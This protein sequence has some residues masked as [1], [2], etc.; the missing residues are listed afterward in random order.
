[1]K[2][3]IS[4]RTDCKY[5]ALHSLSHCHGVLVKHSEPHHHYAS[6]SVTSWNL[7]LYRSDCNGSW[8]VLPGS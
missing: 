2:L 7:Q 1:M 8:D 6:E 5:G 3:T 4:S